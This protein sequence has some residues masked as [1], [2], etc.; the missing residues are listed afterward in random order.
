MIECR[1]VG[2]KPLALAKRQVDDRVVTDA[3][4]R[5][6]GGI[7]VH[8]AEPLV[9]TQ[10]GRA[11]DLVIFGDAAAPATRID[12]CIATLE[13]AGVCDRVKV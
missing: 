1:N 10:S 2:A 4:S 8:Q 6:G 7:E 13:T 11:Q 9:V 12:A 3:M 5:D